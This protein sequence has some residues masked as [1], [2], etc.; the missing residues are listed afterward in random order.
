MKPKEAAAAD[1]KH[2]GGSTPKVSIPSCLFLLFVS[3]L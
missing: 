2:A 1:R 3:K